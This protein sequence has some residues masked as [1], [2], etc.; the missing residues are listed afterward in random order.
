MNLYLNLV[1]KE[2]Y[3]KV[4]RNGFYQYREFTDGLKIWQ[5]DILENNMRL[6][7]VRVS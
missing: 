1:S 5:I 2:I 3:E 4:E 6:I 7:D